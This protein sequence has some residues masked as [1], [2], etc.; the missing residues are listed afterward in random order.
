MKEAGKNL[1]INDSSIMLVCKYYTNNFKY[2]RMSAGGF[3]WKYKE[4]RG[5][6]PSRCSI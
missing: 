6:E 3:I 4:E 1:N 5:D 2:K